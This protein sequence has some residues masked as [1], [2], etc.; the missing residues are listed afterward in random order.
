MH[1]IYN[2]Q[3]TTSIIQWNMKQLSQTLHSYSYQ[4]V[5]EELHSPDSFNPPQ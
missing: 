1:I 5:K 4:N 3:V 2:K